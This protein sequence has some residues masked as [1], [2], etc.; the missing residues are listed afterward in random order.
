MRQSEKFGLTRPESSLLAKDSSITSWVRSRAESLKRRIKESDQSIKSQN[1][2][3]LKS[4]ASK[5]MSSNRKVYQL[6]GL[7][8]KFVNLIFH[9][10]T[11]LILKMKLKKSK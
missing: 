8:I 7:R 9:F 6:L 5:T 1:N 2:F 4:K 11:S 3:L 10:V